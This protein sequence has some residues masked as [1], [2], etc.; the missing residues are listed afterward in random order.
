MSSGGK[1][2]NGFL[3]KGNTQKYEA[4]ALAMCVVCIS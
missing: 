1:I 2:A 4:A 3:L